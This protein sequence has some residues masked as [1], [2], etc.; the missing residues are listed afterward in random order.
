MI[1][2]PPNTNAQNAVGET[3]ADAGGATSAP[4]SAAAAAPPAPE[5]PEIYRP[6][7]S[8]WRT[9]RRHR[10]AMLGL[11]ILVLLYLMAIFAGFLAPYHYDSRQTDLMWTPPT[12]LHFSD[13]NGGFSLRPFVYATRSYLDQD[14]AV[15]F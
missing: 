1:D 8:S 3:V 9:F 5:H 11:V 6:W 15:R 4:D 7:R 10:T 12:S 2:G 14:L 13:E